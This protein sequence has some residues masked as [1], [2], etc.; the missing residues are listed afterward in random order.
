[1]LTRTTLTYS[2]YQLPHY[3]NLNFPL[4]AYTRVTECLPAHKRMKFVKVFLDFLSE[5]R[6]LNQ[7]NVIFELLQQK[8]CRMIYKFHQKLSFGPE[9]CEIGLK[10]STES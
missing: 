5:I 9:T 10:V 6:I 7:D 2:D 8:L 1:M 3:A 4:L